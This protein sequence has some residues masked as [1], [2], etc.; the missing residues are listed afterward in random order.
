[1]YQDSYFEPPQVQQTLHIQLCAC[2]CKARGRSHSRSCFQDP[3]FGLGSLGWNIL[4][5]GRSMQEP[6]QPELRPPVLSRASLRA[7]GPQP[8]KPERADIA[9]MS[10]L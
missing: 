5:E 10:Q 4:C 2:P 7:L 1:M 9:I 8:H 6:L 3:G